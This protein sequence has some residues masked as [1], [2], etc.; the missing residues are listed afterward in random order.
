[1]KQ[2]PINIAFPIKGLNRKAAYR[3]QAPYSTSD[4]LNVRAIDAIATRERGGSRPGLMLSHSEDLGAAIRMLAPMTLALGDGFT[5]FSDTFDGTELSSSWSQLLSE[6]LPEIL[7]DIPA[8]AVD[9]TI[10][11]GAA[12]LDELTIDSTEAY[13]V[14]MLIIPWAGEFNGKYRM[15][16]R[17]TKDGIAPGSPAPDPTVEGCYVELVMTGETDSYVCTLHTVLASTVTIPDVVVTSTTTGVA[18]PGWLSATV[19][20]DNVTV[21][22]NGVKVINNVAVDTHTGTLVGFEMECTVEGGVCLANVFRVQYYATDDVSTLRSMLIASAGGD[23]YY[24][25]T[26]GH[27]T[28]VSSTLTVEENMPLSSCQDGQALYIADYGKVAVSGTDGVAS[29]TSLTSTS[30]GNWTTHGILPLDMVVVISDVQ[31]TAVAGTYKI[32]SVASGAITL[33][34]SAGSG[35]CSFRVERAPKIY[36]PLLKTIS[37]WTSALSGTVAGQTTAGQ[38]PTGCPLVCGYMD[39]LVLAGAE[40]APN[41]W[42]MARKG[43]PL[44]WDYSQADAL[45]AVAGSASPAGVP[46]EPITA[47]IPHSDDYLVIGC[48]NSLWRMM[49]DP[50]AGGTLGC[51]SHAIGVAGPNAWCLMPDGMLVFL[52]QD[53]LYSLDAGGNSFPVPMSRENLPREFLNLNPSAVSVSMAY[54][55]QSKGVHIFLT[56]TSTNLRTHWWLDNAPETSMAM[57]VSS[58]TDRKA[59]WPVS[60]IENHEPTAACI[61]QS[62]AIEDSCVVLG[63]RDGKLRR[64]SDFAESDCGTEFN[65]YVVMGPISLNDDGQVGTL[66]TLD[67]VMAEESGDVSWYT[68]PSLTFEGTSSAVASTGGTWVGGINPTDYPACR[69]QAMVLELEGTGRKWACE[70]VIGVIKEAGKRRIP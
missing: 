38:V 18:S 2:R 69:G 68:K 48:T 47:L 52:S 66:L 70:Q 6:D 32:D 29:G 42:Y 62:F 41:V 31:S 25:S 64:F 13:T 23:L 51:L 15:Y 54:D 40:V 3:Q 20:G 27:L 26:Y 7:S 4:C 37:L 60:L 67:A 44:D 39:R 9:T 1:M 59:F 8:V 43:Y 30:A 63:C 56:S 21:Y 36:D 17:M 11:K 61:V 34:S 46:G 5:N 28:Q 10:S 45:A 65:S 35:A 58:T 50:V 55:L 16:F 14:E 19:D 57:G 53:G 33:K 24:E 49:G 12:V 22:W